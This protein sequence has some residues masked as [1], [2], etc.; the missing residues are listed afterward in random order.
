MVVARIAPE[1][2]LV[3][4]L[5]PQ[6]GPDDLIRVA[7]QLGHALGNQHWPVKVEGA[8]VYVPVSVDK[9]V[10]ETVLRT[11][12]LEGIEYG[13]EECHVGA[14]PRVIPHAHGHTHAR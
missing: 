6:E 5:R 1:E 7:V 4:R 11:H 2:V 12:G 9:T 14:I 3:I 8:T 10:M 13:F